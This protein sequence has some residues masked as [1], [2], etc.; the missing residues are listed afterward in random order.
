ML[1]RQEILDNW[2]MF[3]GSQA[4]NYGEDLTR[5]HD[6][7]WARRAATACWVR[8]ELWNRFYP[9]ASL[10]LHCGLLYGCQQLWTVKRRWRREKEQKTVLPLTQR[11]HLSCLSVVVFLSS[12]GFRFWHSGAEPDAAKHLRCHQQCLSSQPARTLFSRKPACE[13]RA[14][15]NAAQASSQH[16]G[17]SM[18][19]SEEHYLGF[20]LFIR[21]LLNFKRTAAFNIRFSKTGQE[22]CLCLCISLPSVFYYDYYFGPVLYFP[23]FS[24]HVFCT[25]LDSSVA[26]EFFSFTLSLQF[27]SLALDV[28]LL[29]F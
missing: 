22:I 17:A 13:R 26:C 6:E 10:R 11:D 19:N 25:S 4:T 21:C 12:N 15:A 20:Y 8:G 2:N 3:V 14:L 18:W 7:L 27:V 29:F 1:T 28:R 9:P 24:R 23:D 5:N 16:L